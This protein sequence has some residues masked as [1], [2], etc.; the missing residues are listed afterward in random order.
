MPYALPF[1]LTCHSASYISFTYVCQYKK[2]FT[3]ISFLVVFILF[4]LSLYLFEVFSLLREVVLAYVSSQSAI[5]VTI[6]LLNT[7]VL[8]YLRFPTVSTV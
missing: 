1:V 8:L 3:L 7:S 2:S 6:R 4:L 5:Y